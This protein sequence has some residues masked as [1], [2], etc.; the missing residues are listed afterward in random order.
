[1]YLLNQFHDKLVDCAR[2]AADAPSSD[3]VTFVIFAHTMILTQLH[4]STKRI[5]QS[6]RHVTM[7]T[8]V[9][10][11]RCNTKV[12]IKLRNVRIHTIDIMQ[13]DWSTESR[14]QRRHT[15]L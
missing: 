1:M 13:N 6:V 7:V 10:I 14:D 8:Q 3:F 15:Q 12:S 5:Y 11:F 9:H 2:N 4:C